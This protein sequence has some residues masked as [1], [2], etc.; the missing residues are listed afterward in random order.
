M[1]GDSSKTYRRMVGESALTNPWDAKKAGLKMKL[2]FVK[3]RQELQP[4][5][6]SLWVFESAAGMPQTDTSLAV[7]NGS[8]KLIILHENSLKSVVEG[9]VQVSGP[10]LYFV[11]NRDVSAL[12]RS[13]PRRI[14][15]IGI[16]F[17]P[18]GGFPVFGIPMQETA[19]HLFES[20]LVFGHWGR[21]VWERLRNLERVGQKL[22]FI[23]G[24]LV[25]LLEKNR[26]DDRLIH[27]CVRSLELADGRLSIRELERK[28]GYTQRYLE[29]L[30]KQYVGFSPK[31]LAGIFRFQKFYRKWAEGQ[32]FELLKDDLFEHY[33]DQSHFT[34]EFKKMTG[35]SPRRFSLEISNEFG[36][37]LSLR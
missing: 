13:S 10:G 5:I 33:Y 2:T 36:R 24:A 11:G 29:I 18:Q 6:K 31:V 15:F 19:N 4:Y 32:S 17:S 22:R 27:F 30:F 21:R 7:P 35:Y 14:G 37:L 8:P 1:E 26:R 25:S 12:I 23:Q 3:P 9:R 20:D 16:E 28:T 34:K